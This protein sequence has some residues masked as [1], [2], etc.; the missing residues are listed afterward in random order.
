VVVV[1]KIWKNKSLKNLLV[2]FI[3][4]HKAGSPTDPKVFWIHLKPKEIA[5]LFFEKHQEI[6]SNG[7]VKRLLAELGYSYRKASKQLATGIYAKRDEQ[8]KIIT[9]LVLAMSPES[10]VISIDCKKKELLGNLYREGKCYVTAPIKVYDH[11]YTSLSK[12]KV[13]PHGIYD[14]QANKGYISIGN[15]SETAEFIADNIR[16]W[17][18]EYGIHLYPDAKNILILCDAGGGNSYRHHVFKHQMLKLS[19]ELGISLIIAHYPPYCSKW[20]PIEHKLFC[21][22]H[23]AMSGAIFSD[24]KLVKKLIEKTS[25]DTGL[26]V[27]V[28]LN[29]KQYQKG[30]PI[31]KKQIDQKRI[32]KHPIIPE[33][34]Y[35][36]TA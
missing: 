5:C 4:T 18:T 27:V 31:D 35:R 10:P 30:V 36:M 22:V 32:L 19:R 13:I 7:S 2:S 8:F 26:T 21:H 33:L 11:D 25:T 15:S 3:E 16:W 6:V 14:L 20:N 9:E 12:G 17:W 24:Y 34:S 28:R 29:L 1:K 23:K